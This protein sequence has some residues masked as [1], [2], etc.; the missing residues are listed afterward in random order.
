MSRQLPYAVMGLR[1]KKLDAK[2]L[3]Q[4]MNRNLGSRLE[5]LENM[6]LLPYW[7]LL[8]GLLVPQQFHLLLSSVLL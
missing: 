3:M 1:L 6:R 2:W 5:Y 7:S 4:I 8:H